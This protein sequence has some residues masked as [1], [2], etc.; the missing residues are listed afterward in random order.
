[1]C[2]DV[3]HFSFYFI[4]MRLDIKNSL[5][6]IIKFGISFYSREILKLQTVISICTKNNI[7]IKVLFVLPDYNNLLCQWWSSTSRRRRR[8]IQEVGQA[9]AKLLNVLWIPF[10]NREG[11]LS[12]S[13][14]RE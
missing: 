11:H 1:M 5:T 7:S 4:L 3:N 10:E 8:Y 13:F 12:H 6:S 9:P 14:A 2:F